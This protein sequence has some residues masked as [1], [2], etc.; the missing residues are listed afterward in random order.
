LFSFTLVIGV[1]PI[2]DYFVKKK[3]VRGPKT[4]TLITLITTVVVIGGLTS[5]LL[6]AIIGQARVLVSDITKEGFVLDEA[7]ADIVEQVEDAPLLG[8]YEFDKQQFNQDVRD[9]AAQVLRKGISVILNTVGSLPQMIINLFILVG[10]LAIGLP[11]FDRGVEALK[12][13]LP[14]HP[15]I[16]DAYIRRAALMIRSLFVGQFVISIIQGVAMGVFYIIAGI[17][18][19]A[20]WIAVTIIFSVLPVVGISFVAPPMGFVLVLSGEVT[21][22]LVVLFGFYGVVMWLENILRPWLLP[23]EAKLNIVL[24]ILSVFG[25]I[26]LSGGLMGSIYGPVI[27]ILFLTSIEVYR[28]YYLQLGGSGELL[29]GTG[30]IAPTNE[31][32]KS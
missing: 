30:T 26:A 4:A 2:Y 5:I 32:P 10:I 3:W 11:R 17:P 9:A 8:G 12:E 20:F 18:L 28:E 22:G 31:P 29:T 1:K 15:E 24:L 25:G 14:L 7:L 19:P 16:S 13:N 21:S 6:A 27:M 23:E